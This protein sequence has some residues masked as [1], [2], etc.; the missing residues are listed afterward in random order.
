MKVQMVNRRD[1]MRRAGASCLALSTLRCAR[2]LPPTRAFHSVADLAAGALPPGKDE[3]AEHLARV[4]KGLSSAGIDA[5]LVEP[6]RTMMYLTGVSWSLSERLFFLIVPARGSLRWI[7]P[8]FEEARARERAGQAA[9]I[10]LWQEDEDPFQLLSR[11][12]PGSGPVAVEP[13]MREL[14][15]S[16]A[17]QVLAPRSVVSGL[18]VVRSARMVKTERELALLEQANVITKRCLS[19]VATMVREGMTEAELRALM[20]GAQ[21]AAGLRAPW[22][23][24]LFGPNASFPHGTGQGRRLRPGE[25]IL[26]DTG[27]ELHGYQSD[28]SRTFGFGRVSDEGRRVFDTVLAAQRAAFQHLRPGVACERADHAA[29][30]VIE[31]AGFGAG[32]RSFT[33]RLGHGIGL[34]AHEEPYLVK[35]NRLELR[36]GMTMSNEPGIYLPGKLGVRIEDIVAISAEGYRLFGPGVESFERPV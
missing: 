31:A 3:Y 36:A 26:I 16:S 1:L 18:E 27:G 2:S 14:F 21:T 5:L 33:H 29:R 12:L 24:V 9:E 11:V 17:R 7:A 30:A 19:L 8:A 13:A 4:Q 22:A 10:E 23:L 20:V 28:I 32:Y 15:A 35:G 25:L 6:G 34:E